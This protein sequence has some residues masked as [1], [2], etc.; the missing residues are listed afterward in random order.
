MISD[1]DFEVKQLE[2]R[3]IMNNPSFELDALTEDVERKTRLAAMKA[4]HDARKAEADDKDEEGQ[5]AK[6]KDMQ[7]VSG[8]EFPS[9]RIDTEGSDVSCDLLRTTNDHI[10]KQIL[11]TD[12]LFKNMDDM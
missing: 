1:W 6:A 5:T 9:V 2:P 10:S 11:E 7:D 3:D 12:D 4:A 8:L